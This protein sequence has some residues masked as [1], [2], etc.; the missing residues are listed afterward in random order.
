MWEEVNFI[1]KLIEELQD[2]DDKKAYERRNFE[3]LIFSIF[4]HHHTAYNSNKFR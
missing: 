4:L 1:G 2:K 3:K